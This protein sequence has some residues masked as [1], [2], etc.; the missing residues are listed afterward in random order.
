[1]DSQSGQSERAVRAENQGGAASFRH[2]ADTGRASVRAGIADS[3]RYK[4]AHNATQPDTHGTPRGHTTRV[5]RAQTKPGHL[6]PAAEHVPS[7]APS[8]PAPAIPPSLPLERTLGQTKPLTP[9]KPTPA[10][11]PAPPATAIPTI[12][13]EAIPAPPSEHILRPEKPAAQATLTVLSTICPP[14]RPSEASQTST[15]RQASA[16]RPNPK[17]EPASPKPAQGCAPVSQPKPPQHTEPEQ[18]KNSTA[19][20]KR[21][22]TARPSTDKRKTSASST[23]NLTPANPHIPTHA[24]EV[25]TRVNASHRSHTEHHDPAARR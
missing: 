6:C 17:Q 20:C 11:P 10:A 15:P 8:A 25:R 19:G 23:Q 1:V 4:R 3:H 9:R 21:T 5:T 7:Q 22:C 14:K 13:Y 24:R 12:Q 16:K 2:Y 18:E